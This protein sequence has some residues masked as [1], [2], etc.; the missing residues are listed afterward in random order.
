MGSGSSKSSSL[1]LASSPVA[2]TTITAAKGSSPLRLAS[3]TSEP[4]PTT[5]AVS[6]PQPEHLTPPPLLG[7]IGLDFASH[8]DELELDIHMLDWRQHLIFI[9]SLSIEDVKD[10][11]T[12]LRAAIAANTGPDGESLNNDA[13]E[14]FCLAFC[15]H[16]AHVRQ[17]EVVSTGAPDKTAS[18]VN[19][20]GV[21]DDGAVVVVDINSIFTL[22]PVPNSISTV[23]EA[24]ASESHSLVTS[25]PLPPLQLQQQQQQ[26]E[27]KL[28]NVN[29]D[30]QRPILI[31]P[32]TIPTTTAS[33]TANTPSSSIST[34]TRVVTIAASPSPSQ[35]KQL[36]PRF[37]QRSPSPLS[38]DRNSGSYNNTERASSAPPKSSSAGTR[39]RVVGAAA[40]LSRIYAP[41]ITPRSA[42][43]IPPVPTPKHHHSRESPPPPSLSPRSVV[44]AE[45]FAARN[46][47]SAFA[48]AAAAAFAEVA[49]AQ[50]AAADAADEAAETAR[51]LALTPTTRDERAAAHARA[52]DITFG[53]SALAAAESRDP[54]EADAA[55]AASLRAVNILKAVAAINTTAAATTAIGSSEGAEGGEGKESNEKNTTGSENSLVSEKEEKILKNDIANAGS[56]FSAASAIAVAAAVAAVAATTAAAAASAAAVVATTASSAPPSV[57]RALAESCISPRALADAAFRATFASSS[58]A[59]N[60]EVGAAAERVRFAAVR[61]DEVNRLAAIESGG[62]EEGT[63]P[64]IILPAGIKNV[65]G[66]TLPALLARASL[67]R[68]Q[69]AAVEAA[70]HA[71]E[72]KSL[73][74]PPPFPRA[75]RRPRGGVIAKNPPSP[76]PQPAKIAARVLTGVLRETLR[77]I[78]ALDAPLEAARSVAALTEIAEMRAAAPPPPRGQH[79][80][81]PHARGVSMHESGLGAALFSSI[82]TANQG[83]SVFSPTP[84]RRNGAGIRRQQQRT[85][86]QAAAN[87]AAAAIIA[88]TS[89][90]SAAVSDGW[91][92]PQRRSPLH[93]HSGSVPTRESESNMGGGGGSR[94]PSHLISSRA[95]SALALVGG[96]ASPTL[97]AMARSTTSGEGG[98]YFSTSAATP[99]RNLEPIPNGRD[100]FGRISPPGWGPVAVQVIPKA[101]AN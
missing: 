100:D 43:A 89:I 97:A 50:R 69:I 22:G 31:L 7:A 47:R 37:R 28:D 76:P 72:M 63:L 33:T 90:T 14:R 26:Q 96:Y 13:T 29:D 99:R 18:A 5:T 10:G 34:T 20:I 95:S 66:G 39:G 45:G 92:V 35:E 8:F 60:E 57:T 1:S 15:D 82:L 98:D 11:G 68:R 49:S 87:E 101:W 6:E 64:P 65:D 23:T 9:E 3:T 93:H 46:A 80:T 78:R 51:Y 77:E 91:V 21:G 48:A 81:S 59:Y 16:V 44:A 4:A 75:S 54:A 24:S 74:A 30:D 2:N 53:A 27:H 19:D 85:S 42:A 25:L 79:Y 71:E 17:G 62:G 83:N 61:A 70:A 36:Y 55:S 56:A 40:V 12:R 84:S 94:G 67:L 32:P 88:L 38:S 52:S 73:D 58:E 86:P 41:D